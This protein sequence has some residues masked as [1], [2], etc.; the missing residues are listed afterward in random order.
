MFLCYIGVPFKVDVGSK[1]QGHPI[2][3]YLY[4]ITLVTI[5]Q[6]CYRYRADNIYP[7]PQ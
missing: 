7:F 1:H 2:T 3:G 4:Y 5:M 6:Y